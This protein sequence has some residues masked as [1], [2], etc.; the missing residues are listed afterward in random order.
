MRT[1]HGG[2]ATHISRC[3]P[4]STGL[5]RPG[6][7]AATGGER[8]GSGPGLLP[9]RSA[10]VCP[11]SSLGS[12]SARATRARGKRGQAG[13]WAIGRVGSLV[14]ETP[15]DT[16]LSTTLGRA[17]LPEWTSGF[18]W[19]C[20][21][22]ASMLC[23]QACFFL[24]RFRLSPIIKEKLAA[25]DGMGS[26]HNMGRNFSSLQNALQK[27]WRSATERHS[28]FLFLLLFAT[29]TVHSSCAKLP[30][31]MMKL[32]WSRE[33]STFPVGWTP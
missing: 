21:N 17:G 31:N 10:A 33:T 5:A 26:T 28:T 15:R 32:H 13:R 3:P 14:S 2:G 27:I 4:A 29:P 1:W 24:L 16:S 11:F 9:G 25:C 19:S 7:R 30:A 8:G 18:Q 23:L 12:E 6:T 20:D 22:W